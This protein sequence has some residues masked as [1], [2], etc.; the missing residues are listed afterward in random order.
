MAIEYFAVLHEGI[1]PDC[2][3]VLV[4][5]S[6]RAHHDSQHH[7]QDHEVHLQDSESNAAA[8]KLLVG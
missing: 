5:A 2:H 3:K 4:S 7:H 8:I 1:L 6:Q